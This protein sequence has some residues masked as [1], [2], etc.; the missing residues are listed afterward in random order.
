ML[1]VGYTRSSPQPSLMKYVSHVTHKVIES[2][3]YSLRLQAYQPPGLV[4]PALRVGGI[5]LT[6]VF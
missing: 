4:K 2:L 6:A 3:T 1:Y 5:E